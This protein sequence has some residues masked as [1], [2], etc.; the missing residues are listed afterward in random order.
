MKHTVKTLQAMKERGEKVAMVT[1]YD[2]TMARLCAAAGADMILVGDSLGMVMMG[3]PDTV[4]VTM[5]DMIHHTACAA[6]GQGDTFLVADMPF[7]S[8]RTS[9]RE[10]M[11][12]AARLMAEGRAQAVKIEGGADL[13]PLVSALTRGGVPVMGHL[14]L[15]PQSVNTLG[16]FRAQGRDERTAIELIENA[17]ALDEAGVFAMVLECVPA[18]LAACI[19]SRVSAITIGI[20]A[21]AGCD[22]QV[23]V[24]QDL[25]GMYDGVKPRFVK[26]FAEAGAL[27]RR[28]IGEYC[29]E[30]RSGSF[31]DAGH[32]F[33]MGEETLAVVTRAKSDKLHG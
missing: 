30:V 19:T 17:L 12:N 3:L 16:G 21:G 13:C 27:I 32:S 20:G 18:P 29:A 6:R 11:V 23:L 2:Y 25:L 33:A 4:S 15:T 8:Y 31:P 24:T 1:A 26:H 22:G 7:M 9:E 28:G 5:D 14:G 10:A